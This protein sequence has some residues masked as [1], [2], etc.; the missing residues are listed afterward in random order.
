MSQKTNDG[1]SAS[2][3]SRNRDVSGRYYVPSFPIGQGQTDY[4]KY[5]RTV[6]LLSLQK[7]PAQMA[8]PEELL[9]QI[10]HQASELW[11]KLMMHELDRAL[12]FL[13]QDRIGMA[14]RSFKL[15]HDCQRILVAQVDLI[16]ANIS[17]VEYAKIR[18]ALGQGSGMESPGFNWLLEYPAKLWD[19][20]SAV[21]KKHNVTI[22]QIYTEYEVRIELHA[23]AE[24]LVDFDDLFHKWRSHHYNMVERTIGADSNSLKGL[25]SQVLQKGVKTRFFPELLEFRSIYTNESGLA[26]GGDPLQ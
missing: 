24:C 8:S 1:P 4:E 26:Y 19:A 9:F 2:D 18:M 25:S 13:K 3:E 16:A 15:V 17:M 20:F 14:C 5:L 10:T 11:M 22:R 23:L 21:L 12:D 7:P 6:E